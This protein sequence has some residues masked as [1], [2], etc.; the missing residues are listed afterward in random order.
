MVTVLLVV[1]V[2]AVHGLDVEEER[3]CLLAHRASIGKQL[4]V[5]EQSAGHHSW[6]R[7]H[8]E[9]EKA[10]RDSYVMLSRSYEEQ[11]S[12]EQDCMTTNAHRKHVVDDL[13]RDLILLS[14]KVK[15][16]EQSLETATQSLAETYVAITAARNAY[17]ESKVDCDHK[18]SMES[19]KMALFVTAGG[20]SEFKSCLEIAESNLVAKITPLGSSRD[21]AIASIALASKAL[22][23]L[24]PEL[25]RMKDRMTYAEVDAFDKSPQHCRNASVVS[26]LEGVLKTMHQLFASLDEC[27][28]RKEFQLKR[29][30]GDAMLIDPVDPLLPR[31]NGLSNANIMKMQADMSALSM[32]DSAGG[33]ELEAMSML[34]QEDKITDVQNS[35]PEDT[36]DGSEDE[37]AEEAAFE[38]LV[39]A[40]HERT[41]DPELDERREEALKVHEDLL[42][43]A[44]SQAK[45]N[46]G[47]TFREPSP[48]VESGLGVTPAVASSLNISKRVTLLQG[49]PSVEASSTKVTSSNTVADSEVFNDGTAGKIAD[50]ELRDIDNAV[51]DPDQ[52][53][54]QL[55]DDSASD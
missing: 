33:I 5:H 30:L 42:I 2:S 55:L 17:A 50:T 14:E 22:L 24:E 51:N 15:S 36:E 16:H 8:A 26:D 27:P 32:P 1:L 29:V 28:G 13:L 11:I 6:L 37:E 34:Q 45:A 4:P 7:D 10:I 20:L 35:G 21:Q 31:K 9:I 39:N 12:A 53:E 40:N 19:M 25:I 23:N 44:M 3:Q 49:V 43:D 38:D 47:K 52:D 46:E 41:Y 54:V 18:K 48:F